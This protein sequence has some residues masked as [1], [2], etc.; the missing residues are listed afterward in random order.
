MALEDLRRSLRQLRSGV[1]QTTQ[2]NKVLPFPPPDIPIPARIGTGTAVPKEADKSAAI[3]GFVLTAFGAFDG[4]RFNPY[5]L[6]KL[7]THYQPEALPYAVMPWATAWNVIDTTKWHDVVSF[8]HD[9]ILV[10]AAGMPA[11]AIPVAT[12]P[13]PAIP[14]VIPSTIPGAKY[15]D[16]TVNGTEKRV[17]AVGRDYVKSWGGGGVTANLGPATPGKSLAIGPRTLPAEHQ[18]LLGKI[19]Y[20][21]TFW[22]SLDSEWQ[23]SASI[24][25]MLLAAPYLQS[26]AST[27]LVE[28]PLA[29]YGAPSNTSPSINRGY[30]LPQTAVG[31]IGIGE[32]SHTGSIPYDM[33][34]LALFPWRDTVRKQRTGRETGT[35]AVS[36][37]S[38][39]ASH[40]GTQAGRPYGYACGNTKTITTENTALGYDADSYPTGAVFHGPT[41]G[42][43]YRLYTLSN[44]LSWDDGNFGATDRGVTAIT[45]P[46]GSISNSTISRT[47]ETQTITAA[48]TV[49]SMTLVSVAISVTK[50]AGQSRQISENSSYYQ[51]YLNNP[52]GLVGADSGMGMNG[53]VRLTQ[54]PFLSYHKN[55]PGYWNT[56]PEAA[57]N[58]IIAAFNDRIGEF[59]GKKYYEYEGSGGVFHSNFYTS[60]ILSNQTSYS[61]TLAVSAR[62]DL[63]FDE[64]NSVHLWLEST[65]TGTQTDG[66]G[67][68]TVTVT[69][70]LQTRYSSLT[71]ELVSRS[72]SGTLL[73]EYPIAPPAA[74]PTAVPS[75]RLRA[76][77]CPLHQEQGSF[78]G[79]SYCTLAEEAS[80]ATPV[81]LVNFKLKLRHHD[82]FNTLEAAN[83]SGEVVNFIPFNLL[84][85]LYAFVYSADYGVGAQTGQRYSVTRAD[86]FDDLNTTLFAPVHLVNLRDATAGSWASTLGSDSA[87]L[88]RT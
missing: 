1:G 27:A 26:A 49:G 42:A 16:S 59:T 36:T 6:Q 23:F 60:T 81:H 62:D 9:E 11:L 56:M 57:K 35:S 7:E 65:L 32:V 55:P 33:N 39:S 71:R 69:L 45:F 21:G 88:Y 53:D 44:V 4:I 20:T 61:A 64:T 22:D 41:T 82:A 40:S 87:G 51:P 10:N 80:G 37:Y 47:V 67:S 84:E 76:F 31:L 18:A 17:F 12:L 77:F 28:M 48:V 3:R 50:T 68:C 5:T 66:A 13:G 25:T 29:L 75:P 83:A 70:K 85:M 73:P 52:F 19:F 78:K 63:F 24:V 86:R 8:Y 54:S 38:A 15:G 74:T 43:L 79:L 30:S 2:Q 72:Y 58:E 34:W 14:Y 46:A